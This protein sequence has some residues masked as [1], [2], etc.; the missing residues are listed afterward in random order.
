MP[1]DA[2]DFRGLKEERPFRQMTIPGVKR[3]PG[4]LSS[5][6]AAGESLQSHRGPH[7]HGNGY[8]RGGRPDSYKGTPGS[9]RSG[10]DI[11]PAMKKQRGNSRPNAR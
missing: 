7:N 5:L 11:P 10:Q 6:K 4:T 2:D 9:G 3:L 8:D 1:W